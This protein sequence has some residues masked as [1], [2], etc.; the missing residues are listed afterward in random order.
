MTH[1]TQRR[2]LDPSRPGEEIVMLAMV[3]R[4][5]RGI[6]GIGTALT[7]LAAKML[8]YGRDQWPQWT[9]DRF[10]AAARGA[11]PM[12]LAAAFTDVKKVEALLRDLRGDWLARNKKKGYPIS[13]VLSG[14]VGDT[15]RC[16]KNAGLTEHTHLHSLGFFGRVQDLPLDDELALVTM[17]GHGLIAAGRIRHLV[18]TIKDGE[19]TPEEAADDIALPCVCGIGNKK[20]AEE[21]FTRL[22]GKE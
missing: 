8:E 9:I 19:L 12:T 10:E 7:E 20:R 5:H 6:K 22:A 14:L 17:C 21:I 11:T 2:G 18:R 1:T 4:K 13:I 15:H 3:S 16:C